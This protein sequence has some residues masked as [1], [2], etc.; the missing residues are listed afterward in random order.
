MADLAGQAIL[1]TGASTGIGRAA[2]LALAEAGADVGV[3]FLSSED[4]A[5]E[6]AEAIEGMGRRAPLLKADATDSDQV[7]AM[8]D[9]FTET[10][11]RLDTVFANVGALV[12]RRPVV[13][14]T[15]DL[16]REVFAVNVD[17]AFFTC[18]AALR[19]MLP[20]GRGHLILNASVAARTGG[21]GHSVAY[22]ASKGALVSFVRGL[23]KEVAGRGVRVNAVA[24]GVTETPFHEKFTEPERMQA[25]RAKIPV[26]RVGDPADIAR[27][28]VWLAGE[29]EGFMTGETI[30]LTGGI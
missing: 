7:D 3:H 5:R 9:H 30:Y 16:W 4:E 28:V 18:R 1:V 6:V 15:D 12:Q 8:V 22:A 2:A 19:H 13:E 24:P 25:F 17:S 29:S 21:G 20:A 23:A 27:A 26:G 10:L 11:G 14:V